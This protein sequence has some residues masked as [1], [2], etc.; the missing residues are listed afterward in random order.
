MKK[1]SYIIS[2]SFEYLNP[3]EALVLLPND[4]RTSG[5]P[6]YKFKEILMIKLVRNLVFMMAE[7]NAAVSRGLTSFQV[8]ET[9]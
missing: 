4:S 7:C 1:V 6:E 8:L 9:N 2:H 5:N 3:F